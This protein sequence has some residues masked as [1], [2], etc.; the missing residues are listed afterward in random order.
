MIGAVE[1]VDLGEVKE[2]VWG[3]GEVVKAMGTVEVWRWWR[4]CGAVS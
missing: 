4:G 3:E 2:L 1:M